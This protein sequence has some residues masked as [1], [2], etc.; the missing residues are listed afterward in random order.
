MLARR[1]PARTLK[2]GSQP[3]GGRL[4]R[5][6]FVYFVFGDDGL[7]GMEF[8]GNA[9]GSM[10]G[11]GG[12]GVIFAGAAERGRLATTF[13]TRPDNRPSEHSGENHPEL[14]DDTRENS[15]L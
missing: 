6:V 9:C 14:A 15:A 8:T 1:T 5:P 10:A 3:Y 11:R 7:S 4:R 2:V 12:L 13:L